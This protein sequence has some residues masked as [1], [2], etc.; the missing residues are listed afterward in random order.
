MGPWAAR[1]VALGEGNVDSRTLAPTLVIGATEQ[2]AIMR[3][4]IF[5]PLFPIETYD[6]LDAA[7]AKGD[8]NVVALRITERKEDV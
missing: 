8:G 5:G 6:G 2:M 3:E 7:I 4:E 1:I